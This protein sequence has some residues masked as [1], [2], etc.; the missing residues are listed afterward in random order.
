MRSIGSVLL[1]ATVSFV[2]PPD[3][4]AD[5]YFRHAPEVG[6]WAKYEYTSSYTHYVGKPYEMTIEFKGSTL[7][8]CVGEEVIDDRRH[9]WI[10]WRNES[11]T[12]NGDEHWIV[13][14]VLVPEDGLLA[15]TLTTEDV[16]GWSQS[17]GG[18]VEPLD[19]SIEDGTKEAQPAGLPGFLTSDSTAATGRMAERTILV[20]DA[21]VQLTYA[22]S[23]PLP[24]FEDDDTVRMGETLWWPSEDLAF[25][26]ASYEQTLLQS[27]FNESGEERVDTRIHHCSDL[28]ATGTD[29][30]SEFPD[31][32]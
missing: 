1:C 13:I 26:I 3:C 31:H 24:E 10:E 28:V 5:G 25:G 15:G 4:H 30:V 27:D 18:E 17:T 12:P 20:N 16:R 8:K 14:K 19:F 11:V 21:A 32:N 23:A 7:F 9:H 6:E 22:E 29:A 2:S